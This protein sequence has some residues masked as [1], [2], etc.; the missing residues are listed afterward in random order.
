MTPFRRVFV[1][2]ETTGLDPAVHEV[3]EVAWAA[4]DGPVHSLVLPHRFERPNPHALKV[5]GYLERGLYDRARW[6]DEGQLTRFHIALTG[7]TLVGANPAFDA[8][9]LA[10]F[11]GSQPFVYDPEPWHYRLLDVQAYGMAALGLDSMPGLA[12]LVRWLREDG[13]V[14]P[15]SDHT[16]AHDVEATRAV[17][18]ALRSRVRPA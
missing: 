13:H 11:F 9:F 5:N 10:A 1:D 17:F 6:A 15:E 16:A 8:R 7:A 3:V 12:D 2:V 4:D 18:H 14:I